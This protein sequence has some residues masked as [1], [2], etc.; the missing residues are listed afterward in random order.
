MIVYAESLDESRPLKERRPDLV[1]RQVIYRL[2]ADSLYC[3]SVRMESDGSAISPKP[4]S[5]S[6]VRLSDQ[7]EIDS[8]LIAVEGRQLATPQRRPVQC[9]IFFRDP[10]KPEPVHEAGIEVRWDYQI[11]ESMLPLS[12][13]GHD[14]LALS[15]PRSAPTPIVDIILMVPIGFRSRV[16]VSFNGSSGNLI[17]TVLTLSQILASYNGLDTVNYTPIGVRGRDLQPKQ[18]FVVRFW[19]N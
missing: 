8:D 9:L 4:L 16:E 11:A 19:K 14:D 15:N 13:Q 12:S 1:R 2:G 18:R 7:T 6:V 10:L 5:H 17:G 3:V